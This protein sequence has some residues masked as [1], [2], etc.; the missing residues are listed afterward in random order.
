MTGAIAEAH[1]SLLASPVCASLRSRLNEPWRAYHVWRHF[2]AIVGHMKQAES[3]GVTIHD[4][5]ACI[6]FA[7]WHDSVYDPQAE[8]GRNEELSAR[9]CEAEMTSWAGA[10]SVLS[11]AT[12]TRATIGHVLPDVHACPDGALQLDCDLAI[13]AGGSKTIARFERDIRFEYRHVEIDV[14][15]ARRAEVL[16]NFMRR[17][18][19]Y[20]T[21]WAH[22]RWEAAA[23]RNLREVISGLEEAA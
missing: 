12:G 20:L 13:L 11:A 8:H 15:R 18:R 19:I 10:R 21:E 17:P 6:G 2:E 4:P 1:A 7:G 22:A 14:Y 9:L 5:H 3:E 16:R 23:R